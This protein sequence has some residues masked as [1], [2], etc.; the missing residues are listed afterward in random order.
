MLLS[1]RPSEL[2]PIRVRIHSRNPFAMVSAIRTAL[3]HR[4][5]DRDRIAEFTSEA[6]S[7]GSPGEIRRYCESWADFVIPG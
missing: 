3:R 4:H 5:V 7:Q 1:A 2:P 6:L